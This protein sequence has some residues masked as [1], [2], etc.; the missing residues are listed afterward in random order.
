ME[1]KIQP[2]FLINVAAAAQPSALGQ[3]IALLLCHA[4]A[5][6]YH[7]DRHISAVFLAHLL[8]QL[9]NTS[10]NTKLAFGKGAPRST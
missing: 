9:L 10:F 6:S 4:A 7:N 8:Y 2:F 5:M 3:Q 1:K